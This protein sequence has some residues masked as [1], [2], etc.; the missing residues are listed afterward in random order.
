MSMQIIIRRTG[1]VLLASAA[2]A[3]VWA[4]KTDIAN[5]P[6]ITS[7][8]SSV[9]PNIMFVLDNSGSMGQDY[10]PDYVND[11]HSPSSN[12]PA[13]AACFSGASG[14]ITGSPRACAIGDPPYMSSDFNTQYYNPAIIYSPPI[15]SDGTS[16]SSQ[17]D[18]TNVL[19]DGFGKQKTDQY[20]N[21]VN[22]VNLTTSYPDRYWCSGTSG[23]G[24]CKNNTTGYTYPDSGHASSSKYVGGAPYYWSITPTEY[25]TTTA[26]RDCVTS[27]AP[28]TV[29]GIAYNIPAKIRW[30]NSTALTSCQALK[31]PPYIYAKHIGIVNSGS[32]STTGT[33]AKGSLTINDSGSDSPV[34]I[35]AVTVNGVNILSTT[36]ASSPGSGV[37]L[38]SGVVTASTGTNSSSERSAVASAIATGINAA[39][40]TSG[41]SAS[42]SGSVVTITR[43]AN[44]ATPNG[45][46]IAVSSSPSSA[47][48]ATGTITIGSSGST[49]SVSITSVQ[50][51]GVTAINGT[52]TASGGTTTA[53]NQAALATALAN[54]INAKASSPEYTATA[55]ANVVTI[56][57]ATS[58]TSPNGYAVTATQSPS[59]V[60]GAPASASI[61][62]TSA[63]SARASSLKVNSGGSCTLGSSTN[64]LS[65]STSSTNSTSTLA[66]RIA[67]NFSGGSSYTISRSGSTITVT[68]T[69]NNAALNGCTLNVTLASGSASP[70][71]AT[72]A[73]GVNSIN[74]VASTTSMSGGTPG[75]GAIPVSTQTMGSVVTG[76]DPAA[77]VAP[78]RTGV[79]TF[80]RTDIVPGFT[81]PKVSTRTDCAGASSCTYAEEITNFANWYAYY[82][83]RMQMMKS[84]AGR[85]FS[86]I[87]SQYRVGF[88]TI[89]STSSNYLRINDF[90]AQSDGTGQ[91][92]N[93]YTKFY[94][95]SPTGTTPLRTALSTAGRIFA[96]KNPLNFTPSDDPIQYACQK[97]FTILTTD[98]Y[99]NESNPGGYKVDGTAIGDQDSSL[100]RPKKDGTSTSNTLSDVA[101]YYFNTDLRSTSP[102]M[103]SC[104]GAKGA[105]INVCETN[106]PSGDSTKDTDVVQN[107]TT[108]TLG[109]GVSGYMQYNNG[110][111]DD[112]VAVSNGS[113]ANPATGVCAWR[114]AGSTCEWPVPSADSQANIDDLWHAAINGGG[115]YFSASNAN[116]LA[117]SLTQALSTINV[118]NG[119]AAAA[120]TSNPNVVSG[121]N[122]VFSTNFISGGW[123]GEVT[124]QKIDI[125]TGKISSTVDWTAQSQLNAKDPASRT[126]YT[127]DPNGTNRLKPFLWNNLT[128]AE[129]AYFKAPNISGLSQ[130]CAIGTQCL[131]ATAQSAAEGANLLDFIRGVK[132]NE[133][134][135]SDTS[136][137]YRKRSY[138]LNS[139]DI[140]FNLGDIVNSEAVYVQSPMFNYIDSGY[141]SYKSTNGKD[142]NGNNKRDSRIYVASNDGM[143]HAFNADT[144]AEVWAYIPSMIIPNLYKLADK[145]YSSLHQYFVDS[146]PTV[147]DVYFN[148]AWHTILVGGLN[149]GGR[150]YYALDVTNP[151]TP[152]ALWE[153]TY[154][155]TKG[156]G[157]VVDENLGYTF[158]KPEITKLKDGTWVVL[159]TSGYNNVSPG[160]GKGHL[161]VMNAGTGQIIRDI[162]TAT[163]SSS[164]IAGV[165]ATAPCPSGLAQI[166]AWV[167]NNMYDNTT[168]RVYGGDQFGN[169]WRFDI[170]GDIGAAGYDAQLLAT[171]KDSSGNLQPITSKPELGD[172]SGFDI[173][174]VGTGRY[175]GETDLSDQNTQSLYAIKDALD[176]TNYGNPRANAAF[177]QQTI[178]ATTCP[179]NTPPTICSGNDAVRTT[180]NNTVNF[181]AN[182]GWYVDF[183]GTGERVYTDP[184]L[185]LGT[186]T[187]TTNVLDQT[188]TVCS[189]GG[190]SFLYFFDYRTGG[191]VSTSTTNVI[192][193]SLGN[194]L[195]TRPVLVRLPNNTVVA[196]TRLSDGS[197]VTSNV[198][199][200]N[201]ANATKRVSWRELTQ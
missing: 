5:A 178:T 92:D 170:N 71:S 65:G 132:T 42:A 104:T 141:S 185:G 139:T 74:A 158:G 131:D 103:G 173:V 33:K 70:L 51:N 179:A 99:W 190:N 165:C 20:G 112:F 85:A 102:G 80:V 150:S 196:L 67:A 193:K 176:T 182:N 106:D 183:P 53:A 52:V 194:A 68:S 29:N 166:R 164:S 169:V 63:S 88:M 126:I 195:A 77:A 9:L 147:G 12:P 47:T 94:N 50:I 152:V 122:F 60:T 171:L 105:G 162:S 15:N 198:P 163:G 83:T 59:E 154:D 180:S 17:T 174:Y 159:V 22:S 184:Q 1:Y 118:R 81:Y 36:A 155:T 146:T 110:T 136:K 100:P 28:T 156:A 48:N 14:S 49:S 200:G 57:A 90:I 160:D 35:S 191:A 72:F 168:T 135:A 84:A 24:D 181:S 120:T 43:E 41:Y 38:S 199:I 76:A 153:F 4:V 55:S 130:F 73:N 11:S 19:T 114:S 145:Q 192:G 111:S 101:A 96:G 75:T 23:S 25:C 128:A 121:D 79:G 61:K 58:G 177:I 161:Y 134:E 64:L 116:T 140:N 26:L 27:S 39:T 69:S 148:G 142:D 188:A 34:N 129:Q 54:S 31:I 89:N 109:L 32:A 37:T 30:C 137:Y 149:S 143:L 186:L 138:T 13:T 167:E 7:S 93:W 113:T 8:S 98:G 197:T 127:Y 86:P 62:F 189:V 16:K 172:V 151:D 82:R 201:T 40:A 144:G 45:Y 18:P 124:R 95:A 46:P 123:A 97:N 107:M 2:A 87:G 78:F 56:Q 125:G 119:S 44:S 91:K 21:S 3:N 187:V 115:I 175:L 117:S 157:Y 10:T 66:S 6:L 133:G 108:F